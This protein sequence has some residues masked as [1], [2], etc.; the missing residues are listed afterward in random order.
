MLFGNE[1]G[2]IL[3]GCRDEVEILAKSGHVDLLDAQ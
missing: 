1:C 2:Y 3:S